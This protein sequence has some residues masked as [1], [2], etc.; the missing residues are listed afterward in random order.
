MSVDYDYDRLKAKFLEVVGYAGKLEIPEPLVEKLAAFIDRHIDDTMTGY[1]ARSLLD[2][3]YRKRTKARSIRLFGLLHSFLSNKS[4]LID[5]FLRYPGSGRKAAR[6]EDFD[7]AA[8]WQAICDLD[9]GYDKANCIDAYSYLYTNEIAVMAYQTAS[10]MPEPFRTRAVAGIYHRMDKRRKAEI[11]AHVRQQFISGEAEAG[12]RLK[13]MFPYMDRESRSEVVSTHL[14]HSDPAGFFL[15]YLVIWNAEYLGEEEAKRIVARARDFK[16]DY[17]RNRC[18]LK[19]A[20]HLR[21]GEVEEL[22]GQFMAAFN[23]QEAS[24]ELIHNLYHFSAVLKNLDPSRIVSTALEKI[25]SIDDSGNEY[26]AQ[27]KYSEMRFIIPLLGEEH[28]E[29]AF[30]IAATV[31]SGYKRTLMASL[32]AH[33]ANKR[34]FCEFRGRPVCY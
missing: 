14:E 27:G 32:K 12:Y 18:L 3:F 34:D 13:M 23:R 19:L 22:Y 5:I 30:G 26:Y 2:Q 1:Y 11:L 17:L 15:T 4:L 29:L 20:A 9:V 28:R 6:A 21:D 16:S 7:I 33:Y 24:P 8:I 10:A 25:A 31:R